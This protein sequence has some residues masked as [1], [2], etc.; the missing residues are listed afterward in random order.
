MTFIAR[1]N[2]QW[3]KRIRQQESEIA[4]KKEG[5]RERGSKNKRVRREI[6]SKC[7]IAEEK[8]RKRLG[9]WIKVTAKEGDKAREGERKRNITQRQIY[10]Q[11]KREQVTDRVSDQ[12]KENVMME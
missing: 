3:R 7:K 8:K 6:K 12:E 4:R 10:R 1:A 9:K 5:E 2:K 11:R